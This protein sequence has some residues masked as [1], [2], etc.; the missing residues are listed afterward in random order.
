MKNKKKLLL[1]SLF[2]L[3]FVIPGISAATIHSY[4]TF[5]TTEKHGGA[6]VWQRIEVGADAYSKFYGYTDYFLDAGYLW[7]F[8][9]VDVE[10]TVDMYIKMGVDW[11]FSAYME[12]F[13]YYYYTSTVKMEVWYYV[14]D[15][16]AQV[17]NVLP[18]S[19][20]ISNK[21]QV[22]TYTFYGGFAYWKST[23]RYDNREANNWYQLPYE[24]KGA[25]SPKT[26]HLIVALGINLNHYAQIGESYS[27]PGL[28]DV[29]CISWT[30]YWPG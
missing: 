21:K 2:V 28:Y 19:W 24:M 15:S 10:F 6:G 17:G 4:Y 25:A 3:F 14:Q 11:D 13:S 27:Y 23:H 26:Y 5:D 8:A 20:T 30:Q 18:T 29:D 7:I 12:A 16:A 22:A 9:W 1:T